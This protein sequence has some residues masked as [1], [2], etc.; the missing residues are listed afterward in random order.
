[1]KK[2]AKALNIG[3]AELLALDY[4]DQWR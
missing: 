3:L 2:I 4:K 1:L